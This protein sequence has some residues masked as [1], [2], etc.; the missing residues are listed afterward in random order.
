M[1]EI[2]T[3]VG[4]TLYSFDGRV[5]EIFGTGTGLR[6]HVRNMYIE[7]KGPDRK[8]GRIVEMCHG[9]PGAPAARHVWRYSAKEWSELTELIAFLEVVSAAAD[10]AAGR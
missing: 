2:T 3:L 10:K 9:R 6:M 5:L 1:D 8:G 7:I 4:S